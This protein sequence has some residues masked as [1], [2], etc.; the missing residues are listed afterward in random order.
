VLVPFEEK[1]YILLLYRN[2]DARE[3]SP[4]PFKDVF[5]KLNDFCNQYIAKTSVYLGQASVIQNISEEAGKIFT[6]H[7]NNVTQQS[8]VCIREEDKRIKEEINID[9]QEM[10]RWQELLAK[11]F[12]DLVKNEVKGY[13]KHL[14]QR[15]QVNLDLL[16][17]FHSNF[18]MMLFSVAEGR[19]IPSQNIFQSQSD[20][21]A[22][23][24]SYETLD[25]LMEWIEKVLTMFQIKTEGKI[26]DEESQVKKAKDMICSNLDKNLSCTEIAD[27]VYLN[28][29]YLSRLFKREYG[30]S[31]KDYIINEKIKSA[32]HLLITTNLSV[33]IIAS[34]VGYS[35]FSHF[36]QLF[37][38]VEGFS[39]IEYRQLY[40]RSKNR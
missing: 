8:M 12:V 31:L 37:R 9:L 19:G 16:M 11:G 39:P 35:N 20:F 5:M 30:L 14:V 2:N 13:L 4:Y 25:T 22:F 1:G 28:S 6:M 24:K 3:L 17:I 27:L 18:T 21:E 29:E 7:R 23:M 32:K 36:T 33:G 15:G 40:K 10:K 26:E 38:K 34:K